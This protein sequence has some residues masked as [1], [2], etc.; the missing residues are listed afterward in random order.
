MNFIRKMTTNVAKYRYNHTMYRIRDPKASLKFYTEIL[1]M[2]LVD[3]HHSDEAK[4]SLYFLGYEDPASEGLVRLARQGL[5]ELTH[6]HGTENDAS[7]A[8]NTGNGD[9]GGYGHIAITVDDLT[10]A[11][12]R[13]D[14]FGVKFV[15]RPEEGRM[16]HIA[17][18]ADPDG[19]RVEILENPMLQA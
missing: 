19:Y 12:A 8:Y 17:F 2:K 14:E 13:F 18:I 4:F 11:C 9:Q 1:G 5:L 10:A 6:N 3:E 7:F 16:R 15:K